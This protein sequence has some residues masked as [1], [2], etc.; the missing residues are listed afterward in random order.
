VVYGIVETEALFFPQK[1]FTSNKLAFQANFSKIPKT[2]VHG[3]FHG[4]LN[5]RLRR[6]K[7]GN[8]KIHMHEFS[9]FFP[10]IK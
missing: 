7:Q 4:L 3:S 9:S 8:I 5:L 1:K 2:A 10:T 6:K